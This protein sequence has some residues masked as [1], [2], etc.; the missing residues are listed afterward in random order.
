LSVGGNQVSEI[1]PDQVSTSKRSGVDE[2]LSRHA[3]EVTE[4]LSTIIEP[5]EVDEVFFVQS[6]VEGDEEV[7]L[8]AWKGGTEDGFNSYNLASLVEVSESR[9]NELGGIVSVEEVGASVCD[10]NL[11]I[12]V[13]T[14]DDLGWCGDDSGRGVVSVRLDCI[15]F[16]VLNYLR[17]SE[18]SAGGG[19]ETDGEEWIGGLENVVN[20]VEWVVVGELESI[21]NE[22]SEVIVEVFN[23]DNRAANVVFRLAILEVQWLNVDTV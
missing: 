23:S 17:L 19:G 22:H 11:N 21:G 13:L 8:A 9:R 18:V 16:P 7:G 14:S 6:T 3:G 5:L 12:E 1:S 2:D 4:R 20:K 10:G 15:N